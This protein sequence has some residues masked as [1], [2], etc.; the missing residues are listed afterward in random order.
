[1]G[2]APSER[3]GYSLARSRDTRHLARRSGTAALLLPS[4]SPVN[5]NICVGEGRIPA[6]GGVE[7]AEHAMFSGIREAPT[8]ADPV[9][10]RFCAPGM[11]VLSSTHAAASQEPN[12]SGT[13]VDT[14]PWK[15]KASR[16][17]ISTIGARPP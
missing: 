3:P 6:G 2:L 4:E 7:S 10:E 9:E 5:Q 11:A 17:R 13:P 15:A 12:R 8:S 16:R 1:M 14:V